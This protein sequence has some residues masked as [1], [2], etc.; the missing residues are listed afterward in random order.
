ME[1]S[2]DM[3]VIFCNLSDSVQEPTWIP[4]WLDRNKWTRANRA[5]HLIIPTIQSENRIGS[6]KQLCECWWPCLPQWRANGS[7]VADGT[8]DGNVL[9]V[10]G[11]IMFEIYNV[12][13]TVAESSL[14]GFTPSQSLSD[15]L[16]FTSQNYDNFNALFRLLTFAEPNCIDMLCPAYYTP[17]KHA[18]RYIFLDEQNAQLQQFSS[19]IHAWFETNKTFDVYGRPLKDRITQP[20]SAH[21]WYDMLFPRMQMGLHRPI[22]RLAWMSDFWG[23]SGPGRVF[24]QRIQTI[25][26]LGMRLAVCSGGHLGWVDPL[27]RPGD[28]IGLLQGSRLPVVLRPREGGGWNL[29]GDAIVDGLM[30]GESMDRSKC[31]DLAIY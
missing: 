12:S 13:S 25:L 1:R 19:A 7:L 20:K 9:R 3:I 23:P 16:R 28:R 27:A 17:L 26:E 8:I 30:R 11:R 18:L 29:V 10:K 15:G 21:Y 22:Q 14:P 5:M 4:N 2:F 6:K 24:T 31:E